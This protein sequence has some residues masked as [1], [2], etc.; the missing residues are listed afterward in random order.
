MRVQTLH[1]RVAYVARLALAAK[2]ER[3]AI[4]LNEIREDVSDLFELVRPAPRE[5]D[6]GKKN[7][8]D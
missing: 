4:E 3:L 2:Q 1:Y 7:H 8:D 5:V 6:P